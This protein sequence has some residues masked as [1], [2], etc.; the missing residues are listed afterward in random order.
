MSKLGDFL[1]ARR[2][3]ITPAEVGL[4]SGPRRRTPGLRRE[5]VAVLAAISPTYLAFLEQGRDVRPSQ[6]VLDALA[7]TLHLTPAERDY[8]HTLVHG[9][10]PGPE[11]ELTETLSPEIFELVRRLDPHPTY[12]TGR[13]WDIL[14]AN[15]AARLLWTDWNAL[16]PSERNLLLWMFT[17]PQA[18]YV[19][20]EWEAEAAAQLARYR[21]ASVRH[22]DSASFQEL[23]RLLKA[24]SPL[25]RALWQRHNIAPLSSGRKLLRHH[26][27]GELELRHTVLQV[28]DN[29]E[30]KL[31]TFT[32]APADMER[33]AALL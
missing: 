29:P 5:E 3:A 1:R 23:N 14:A 26:Q 16:P 30:Q 22:Q 27:L 25:A 19:F 17:A 21:A 15:R 10:S 7:A 9:T 28:A 8:I 18:R 11:P 4:P 33:I 20:V 6:Q 24:G 2:D 32:S 12:V 31:V 13:R